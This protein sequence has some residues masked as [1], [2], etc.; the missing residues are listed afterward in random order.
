MTQHSTLLPSRSDSIQSRICTAGVDRHDG[1]RAAYIPGAPSSGRTL[2]E[3]ICVD[4]H[5]AQWIV[6]ALSLTAGPVGHIDVGQGHIILRD[7]L[8]DGEKSDRL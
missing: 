8:L 2:L 5:P 1:E 4:Q 7:V 3:Q 6:Y